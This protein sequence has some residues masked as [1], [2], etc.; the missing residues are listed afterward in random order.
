[1]SILLP[2][3]F[4]DNFARWTY[5][6]LNSGNIFW[7]GCFHYDKF[8]NKDLDS[9]MM[10]VNHRSLW[11]TCNCNRMLN[12]Y[13]RPDDGLTRVFDDDLLLIVWLSSW[14][15]NTV[16]LSLSW[17]KSI[18]MLSDYLFE[19]VFSFGRHFIKK[20]LMKYLLF[21]F[22]FLFFHLFLF[23]SLD[24]FVKMKRKFNFLPLNFQVQ[25]RLFYFYL[26]KC[27][28]QANM[29]LYLL[30]LSSTLLPIV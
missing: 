13:M 12:T 21:F 22:F 15:F 9:V 17:K 2:R 4:Q 23:P 10:S 19:N 7:Y 1:M 16:I 26:H 8:W 14:F 27:L 6:R 5:H 29:A 3:F 11:I 24:F 20:L 30:L 28:K 18:A 25:E